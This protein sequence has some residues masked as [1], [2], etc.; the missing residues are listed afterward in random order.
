[1]PNAAISFELIDRAKEAFPAERANIV[2]K[3]AVTSKGIR[4]AARV[5]EAVARNTTTFDIEVKQGDRTDQQRSGRCWMF[6]SLNTMR[7]RVI[8]KYGLKT[9]EFSQAYPL[10]WDKLEKS[11]WFLENIIDTADEPR[12]GRLVAFLLTDPVGDGGHRRR[13]CG[14]VSTPWIAGASSAAPWPTGPGLLSWLARPCRS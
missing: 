9:F 14:P 8:G 10:F 5:P 11:N 7:A 12:D 1:M 2:A 4:A 13:G 6:A 3:N